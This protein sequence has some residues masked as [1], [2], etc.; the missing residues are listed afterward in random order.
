[1]FTPTDFAAGPWAEA[2]QRLRHD[3]IVKLCFGVI[4]VLLLLALA[5]PLLGRHGPGDVD[6]DNFAAAPS[7]G[8]GHWFG[9]DTL[10]RDLFVRV[11]SGLRVSLL[12]AALATLVSITVGISWGAIAGYAGGRID[13][14]MMRVVDV[15]YSL[16][17]TFFVIV[18][19]AL[20]GSSLTLLCFAIGAVGWLTMA[21][22]VRGQAMSLRE[23]E[24]V[25]AAVVAGVPMRRILSRHIVPN[26]I[27]PIVAYGT[28]LVPQIILCESLLAFLGLG[29]QEPH[30]SLGRLIAAG[31]L[32]METAP[33]VLVIP[34]TFLVLLLA[35]LSILGDALRDSLDQNSRRRA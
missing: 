6:W 14:A 13:A 7:L 4:G 35:A 16:P 24:F 12:V 8:S 30:A 33:W 11:L 10:G 28:L 15:L 27:G 20:F 32:E 31:A 9:T 17:Y 29:V 21:R 26:T 18:L 25:E 1:M 23:R 22:I 34:A 19:T 5:A 3:R 2:L